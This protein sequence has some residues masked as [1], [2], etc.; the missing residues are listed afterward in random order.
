MGEGTRSVVSAARST[1]SAPRSVVSVRSSAPRS[2]VSVRSSAP[3]S[4]AASN[5]TTT[6]SEAAHRALIQNLPTPSAST[7][8]SVVSNNLVPTEVSAG[9]VLSTLQK[10]ITG[11]NAASTILGD[12]KVEMSTKTFAGT[13]LGAAAGAVLAYAACKSEESSAIAEQEASIAAHRRHSMI[14]SP[15]LAL[16]GPPSNT[17]AGSMYSQTSRRT[18]MRAIDA[19]PLISSNTW[20]QRPPYAAIDQIEYNSYHNSEKT[21]SSHGHASLISAR[22]TTPS[23]YEDTANSVPNLSHHSTSKASSRSTSKAPSREPSVVESRAPTELSKRSSSSKKSSKSHKSSRSKAPSTALSR[24]LEDEV[25]PPPD[26]NND[27]DDDLMTVAPSDSISCVG[28]KSRSRS[29]SS[30]HSKKDSS[31]RSESKRSSRK[32][33]EADKTKPMSESGRSDRTITQKRYKERSGSAV[34]L[35]YR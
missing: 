16:P 8:P 31:S 32:A 9:T 1:V 25:S 12:S 29:K 15:M 13:I 21:P 6:A 17:P 20:P 26:I 23:L 33:E 18:T 24:V 35:P 4:V 3:R 10:S 34:T 5:I 2:V 7:Q 19:P 14:E 30:R 22:R 28:S 27:R 11:A